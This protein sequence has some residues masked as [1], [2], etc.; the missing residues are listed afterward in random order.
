M[1]EHLVAPDDVRALRRRRAAA[2]R[3]RDGRRGAAR[4]TARRTRRRSP[5]STGGPSCSGLVEAYRGLK[6]HLGLMDFSDQIALARAA[7]RR[8]PEVGEIEREKF[9]V[10]LLDEYQDT[11]VAQALMLKRLFSGPDAGRRARPPGHRGRRPQP[12]DLRLARRLGLQ[13]PRVRPRLPAARR[14]PAPTYP[15]T[16]QPPLR[17]ADPRVANHLAGRPLRRPCPTCSPLEAEAGRAAGRGARDASTTP[18]TTSSPGWPTGR[19]RRTPRARAET[20]ARCW[21]RS[22]C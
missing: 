20:T 7:G 19:S 21:R 17:R 4:P 22:A 11:S 16:R 14:R 5:P 10:V 12:G 3:R 18:T 1:S 2:V 9:R 15:L 13:H 6:R 8:A